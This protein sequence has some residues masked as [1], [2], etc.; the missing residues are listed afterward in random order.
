MTPATLASSHMSHSGTSLTPPN[1]YI[2]V[3]PPYTVHEYLL[4][5]VIKFYTVT[6]LLNNIKQL[7]L[8]SKHVTKGCS[9]LIVL[10]F[11]F[12]HMYTSACIYHRGL[13]LGLDCG[14][15]EHEVLVLGRQFSV[16]EDPEAD[17]GLMLAVAQD[18]LRKKQFEELPDLTRAFSYRDQHK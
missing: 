6:S 18:I 4:M 3:C 11:W 8:D 7:L 15:S 10:F 5:W 2:S 17:M 13:L 16:R 14:L 12:L 1:K 9:F